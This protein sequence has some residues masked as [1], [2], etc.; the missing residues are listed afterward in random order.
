MKKT[1]WLFVV[2]VVLASSFVWGG[3]EMPLRRLQMGK[4]TGM[5]SKLDTECGP[6]FLAQTGG[7]QPG[8]TCRPA[9]GK[10]LFVPFSKLEVRIVSDRVIPT[11]ER[12]LPAKPGEERTFVLRMSEVAYADAA[13]LKQVRKQ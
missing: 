10:E 8:I 11:I 9:A 6:F 5:F 13:C 4:R 3:D 1:D 2:L 12:I 7:T